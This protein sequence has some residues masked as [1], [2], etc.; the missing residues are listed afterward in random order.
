MIQPGATRP[1]FYKRHKITI[2]YEYTNITKRQRVNVAMQKSTGFKITLKLIQGPERR[3][4]K[5]NEA[6][7]IITQG[8]KR[9]HKG[10][11]DSDSQVLWL[12]RCTG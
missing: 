7:T 4:R 6:R 2:H 11:L 12:R 5:S 9:G 8:G 3:R 10:A 1:K